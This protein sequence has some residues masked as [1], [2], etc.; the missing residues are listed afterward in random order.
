MGGNTV[1]GRRKR[2]ERIVL[3]QLPRFDGGPL[4]GI[5]S[6]YS[7]PP[8][9][10]M[11][12]V[13]NGFL[14]TYLDIIDERLLKYL[15]DVDQLSLDTVKRLQGCASALL[16]GLVIPAH[17]R[18]GWPDWYHLAA[19][20]VFTYGTGDLEE[21][22]YAAVSL[23]AVEYDGEESLT[24]ADRAYL[25]ALESQLDMYAEIRT[26]LTQGFEWPGRKDYRSAET[27]FR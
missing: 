15:D 16:D 4:L 13:K 27:L 12:P 10:R 19:A 11:K 26:R 3:K 24:E 2:S 23:R 7:G 1:S 22:E 21:L 14:V 5:P 17:L 25:Q 9:P 18:E 6:A 20:F 8:S